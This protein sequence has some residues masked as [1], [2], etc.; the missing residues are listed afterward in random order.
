MLDLDIF[1]P[2]TKANPYPAYA[3]LQREAP[4]AWSPRLAAWLVTG[5][6]EAVT[7]LQDHRTFS[8]AER[9]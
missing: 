9:G 6:G 5:Y 8:N 2:A 4:V 3:A 1:D 7:V